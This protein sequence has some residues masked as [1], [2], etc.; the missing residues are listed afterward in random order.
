V[1][2]IGCHKV[3]GFSKAL[4]TCRKTVRPTETPKPTAIAT[5]NGLRKT[6]RT[7]NH[8]FVSRFIVGLD[9]VERRSLFDDEIVGQNTTC[10]LAGK[11]HYMDSKAKVHLRDNEHLKV[12]KEVPE[13][14]PVE[15]IQKNWARSQEALTY[16]ALQNI[17]GS[18]MVLR[19]EMEKRLLSSFQR[20]PVLK[21]SFCGLETATKED[22]EIQFEDFLNNPYER[23]TPLG[24]PHELM[25]KKL[26][27]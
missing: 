22:L 5:K 12:Q 2:Y 16:N 8:S 24:E 26:N 4:L 10:V 14:H 9:K 17:Y 19:L 27:L 1:I 21:S 25:E 15:Y 20:L 13:R 3:R 7:H 23:E 11:T 18:H 6:F